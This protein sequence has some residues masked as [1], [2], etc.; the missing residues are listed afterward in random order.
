MEPIRIIR[1]IKL[2]DVEL[3]SLKDGYHGKTISFMLLIDFNRRSTLDDYPYLKGL[4]DENSFGRSNFIK[5]IF[6][7]DEKLTVKMQHEIVAVAEG[8]LENKHDCDWNAD[9]EVVLVENYNLNEMIKYIDKYIKDKYDLNIGLKNIS[10][11]KY[12]YLSQD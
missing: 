4:E 2:K 8:F 10:D 7:T 11:S 12:K 5:A 1:E 9:F 3:F 6:F